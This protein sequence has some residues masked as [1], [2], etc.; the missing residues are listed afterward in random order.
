[1]RTWNLTSANPL[2]LTIAADAALTTPDYLNDMIWQLKMREGEPPALLVE[3]SLG[4]RVR[5]LAMFPRFKR[6]NIWLT[7]PDQF[8][9]KPALT[10]FSASYLKLICMPYPT[11][12][13]ELEYWAHQSN[14]LVGRIT[15]RNISLIS[16]RFGFE[17]A[18]RLIPIN[19]SKNF[20]ATEMGIHTVLTANSE[21][22]FPVCFMTGGSIAGSG[23]TAG[24]E[25]DIDLEK[26]ASR[27]LTWVLAFAD[28]ERASYELA[29]K[30]A[31][32]NQDAQIARI[33]LTDQSHIVQIETGNPDLDAGLAFSQKAARLL[34]M[35]NDVQ[36][37]MLLHRRPED[38]A[39][40]TG[41]GRDYRHGWVGVSALDLWY[42]THTIGSGSAKELTEV[43]NTFLDQQSE[44][45]FLSW[46]TSLNGS[47]TNRAPQPLLAS[48]AWRLFQLT[49][50]KSWL[51]SV[52]PK[53][54]AFCRFWFSQPNDRDM[55]G[56]PEWQHVFQSGFDESN[57]THPWNATS[58]GVPPE[59]VESPSLSA[60]LLNELTALERISTVLNSTESAGW[61][62]SQSEI[63]LKNLTEVLDAKRTTFRYRD[64][65]THAV[66]SGERLLE[67]AKPGLFQPEL[68]FEEPKRLLF[69]C[70]AVNEFTRTVRVK[71]AGLNHSKPVEEELSPRRIQWL[72][73]SGRA[74][75]EKTFTEISSIEVSGLP[76]G[77]TC[78]LFTIN[79]TSED[80]SL[81]TPL[82]SAE[83]P[84]EI[85]KDLIEKS[86]LPKY[87]RHFG[88]APYPKDTKPKPE[89]EPVNLPYNLLL[90]QGLLDRG[91]T[92]KASSIL[93]DLATAIINN[94]RLNQEFVASIDAVTGKS[95]ADY[96]NCTGFIP[97]DFF[98]QV[99]GV[100]LITPD[101]IIMSGLNP[102][103]FNINVQFRGVR[104]ECARNET[105]I[106]FRG[107]KEYMYNGDSSQTFL[108]NEIGAV[109][110]QQ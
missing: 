14:I 108:I 50:N 77:D 37:G 95:L 70:Q 30:T 92:E 53:L 88:F 59:T 16:D 48:S 106:K 85:S 94:L 41:D 96:N 93:M 21:D 87:R 102:F 98:L 32:Q 38:G 12:Q 19:K 49:G 72:H 29:R 11:S 15:F 13:V 76:P 110:G 51:T 36:P 25:L 24:L 17:W 84:D 35:R 73:G 27:S 45:G 97:V 63:L 75:T 80:L 52:F 86:L 54:L 3:S 20:T 31:G 4:L 5:S 7:D 100:Q 82:W 83:L 64:A 9:Q 89:S 90:L 107:G 18:A 57:L 69:K 42:L 39:S 56:Y 40:S 26:D 2:H 28:D 58:Q 67:I 34:F 104:I 81:L 78:E 8:H 79:Y 105:K 44:D 23:A 60:M 101:K 91:E 43:F 1:M 47:R 10:Q 109:N 103:P 62:Q 71:I 74:A 66:S 22:L 46:R 65:E 33:D 6:E 55:D 99:A 68:K 61:L